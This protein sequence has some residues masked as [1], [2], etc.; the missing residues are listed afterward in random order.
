MD[1][2][3]ERI[4]RA[5][6][7]VFE[8][9]LHDLEHTCAGGFPN[10]AVR[11]SELES[12]CSRCGFSHKLCA[13]IDELVRRIEALEE[14]GIKLSGFHFDAH[15]KIN[16]RLD[17]LEAA[18]PKTPGGPGWASWNEN[19]DALVKAARSLVDSTTPGGRLMDP[20]REALKPFEEG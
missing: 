13:C 5:R 12:R 1:K 6:M 7:D 18:A 19:V 11:V 20:L 17:A 8:K 4:L 14:L 15:D 2:E 10:L 3:E 16:K 9:R